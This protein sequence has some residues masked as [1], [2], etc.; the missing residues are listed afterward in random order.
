MK[1]EDSTTE[2]KNEMR[3]G[4]GRACSDVEMFT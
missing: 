1:D 2:K 3:E 4:N